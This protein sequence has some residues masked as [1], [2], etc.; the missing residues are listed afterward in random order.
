MV[1]ST[2]TQTNTTN[3]WHVCKLYTTVT[4]L[5]GLGMS[6]SHRPSIWHTCFET[7]HTSWRCGIIVLK[8]QTPSIDLTTFLFPPSLPL[9]TTFLLPNLPSSSPSSLLLL[10]SFFSLLPPPFLI[11]FSAFLV[12]LSSSSLPLLSP[13]LRPS[14]FLRLLSP[15]S[16]LLFSHSRTLLRTYRSPLFMC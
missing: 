8:I 13:L 15:S 11:P 4:I 5:F 9:H 3:R 16:L 6:L 12:P 1:I 14:P 10:T 7:L 2:L